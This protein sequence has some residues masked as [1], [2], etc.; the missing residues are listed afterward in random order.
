MGYEDDLYEEED[1][2]KSADDDR[3]R[4]DTS[5]GGRGFCIWCKISTLEVST[6]LSV[7][8][9]IYDVYSAI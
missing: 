5:Q 4:L 6:H 1:W 3:R 7:Y 2:V 8:G 9:I